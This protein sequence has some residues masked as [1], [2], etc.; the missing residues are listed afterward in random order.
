MAIQPLF[1]GIPVKYSGLYTD[2]HLIDLQD[3]GISL[4]GLAK[5]SNSVVDFYLHGRIAKSSQLYQVRLFAK[6]PADGSLLIDII[7]LLQSGQLPLYMPVLCDL[8]EHFIP[9]LV[10][11]IIAK[12]LKRPDM[13]EKTVD[14]LLELAHRHAE[15]S[16]DVHQGHMRDKAW[17]QSHIDTLASRNRAPLRQA[18]KPIGTTCRQIEFGKSDDSA[19]ALIT[20]AEASA[21]ASPDNLKVEDMREYR[22]VFEGVDTTNG[23]CKVK[24]DDSSVVP[25]KIT[26][27]ALQ[28]PLNVYTHSLDTQKPI[29]ISAKAVTKDG[30][31]VRLFISDGKSQ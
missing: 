27:P 9:P 5:L 4:Q 7:A 23:S 31:I 6:P 22:V 20:E 1:R 25:G 30:A 28:N 10:K 2:D 18:V 21:L 12:T 11:A 29:T 8:A 15:F 26:D 24:F 17:L 3:F 19:H 14:G 16:H 13:V